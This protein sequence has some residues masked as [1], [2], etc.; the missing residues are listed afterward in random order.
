[1]ER[2]IKVEY[3]LRYNVFVTKVRMTVAVVSVWT[4]AGISTTVVLFTNEVGLWVQPVLCICCPLALIVSS[5]WVKRVRDRHM[6]GIIRMNRYFGL[7]GEKFNLLRSMA[8][9][10]IELVRLNM[11]TGGIVI[12]FSVAGA[13]K[14]FHFSARIVFVIIGLVYNLSNPFIY[15]LVMADLRKHYMRFFRRFHKRTH[16]TGDEHE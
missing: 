14:A 1:M 2:Y 3:C 15:M 13:C 11:L 7:H 5:L 10:V 9:G 16:P 4:L 8:N 6:E 12:A